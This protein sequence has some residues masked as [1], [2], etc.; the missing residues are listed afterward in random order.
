[1]GPAHRARRRGPAGDRRHARPGQPPETHSDQRLTRSG[2]VGRFLQK[3]HGLWRF[4]LPGAYDPTRLLKGLAAA[5]PLV[6]GIHVVTFNEFAG[7]EEWR[8]TLRRDVGL[9]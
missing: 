1:M 8:R 9:G 3:Q 2:L 4:F 7:A 5:A 6:T